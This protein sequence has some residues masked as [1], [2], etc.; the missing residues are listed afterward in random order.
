M[1]DVVERGRLYRYVGSL[2]GPERER[3][4]AVLGAPRPLP[5]PGRGPAPAPAR[6]LCGCLDLAEGPSV[7]R[8]DGSCSAC[9][10]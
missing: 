7:A 8:P 10:P 2:R 6:L 4:A 9:S 3:A 1:R 5:A